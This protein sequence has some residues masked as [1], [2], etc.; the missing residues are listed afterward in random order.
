MSKRPHAQ[1]RTP[2]L[3]EALIG[4]LLYKGTWGRYCTEACRIFSVRCCM[5]G[6][7]LLGENS[8]T[9]MVLDGAQYGTHGVCAAP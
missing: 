1:G 7:I 6:A 4:H 5:N 9:G 2:A 3:Y 8:Y